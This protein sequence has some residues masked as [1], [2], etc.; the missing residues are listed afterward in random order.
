M[1]RENLQD[2]GAFPPAESRWRE[3]WRFLRAFLRSPGTVGAVWPSSSHLAGRMLEGHPLETARTVVELGP[4]TGAFTR[5]VVP[6]LGRETLFLAIELD[7]EV[8][9]RLEA[10]FPRVRVVNDSA[11][12]LEAILQSHG[13]SRADSIISGIPWAAMPAALQR[14]ILTQVARVLAP[15][16]RFSTFA[17]VQSPYTRKGAACAR[18]LRELFGEVRRS[19]VVW[20]NLPPAFVYHCT[21]PRPPAATI[22]A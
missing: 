12:R 6:R 14:E 10:A 11:T 3:A 7:A 9:R 20:R 1:S 4:G 17:Y 19:P 22:P 21:R 5:H 8:A 13:A 15:E 16:G 18:L 2:G